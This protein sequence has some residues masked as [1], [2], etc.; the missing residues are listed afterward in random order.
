MSALSLFYF[1]IIFKQSHFKTQT[2]K[3]RETYLSISQEKQSKGACDNALIK[4]CVTYV[5]VPLLLC[6]IMCVGFF[7]NKFLFF[8]FPCVL[9]SHIVQL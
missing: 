1:P 7:S 2:K 8:L 9:S 3:E 5:N 4:V 6:I